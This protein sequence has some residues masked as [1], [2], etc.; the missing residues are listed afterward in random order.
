MTSDA[1]ASR[2]ILD[3]ATVDE[4]EA[5]LERHHAD[6]PEAWLRIAKSRSAIPGISITAALDGALCF[7]WIDGQ[8]RTND[9]ES[10]LQRFSPRR[11]TS[12]WSQ[13]N[14]EK[15]AALEAAGRV[16]PAGHAVVE[17][18][19][20]DG[21]WDAAY[22]RQR[23]A[24]VPDDLAAALAGDAVAAEAFAKLSR[25][26]RYLIILGLLKARTPERRA[27]LVVRAVRT[28]GK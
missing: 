6:R 19:K 3:F 18:A 17:A 10:F 13:I 7:G 20:A 26:D 23:T 27:E 4:W 8:R 12:S 2:T 28:L 24:E 16:R 25:T 14:V 22:E 5:W 9:D 11:P 15:F 1:D 21:R